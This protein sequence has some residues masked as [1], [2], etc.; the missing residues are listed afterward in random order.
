[1]SD[2]SP[3]TKGGTPVQIYDTTLR[4]GTQREGISLACAD[5]LRIAQQLDASRRRLHRGRLARLEPEGRRA[6]SG[7]RAMSSGRT[8]AL[9]AFGSTRRVGIAADDDPGLVALL[10]AET[11]VCT[12]FGKSSIV[13]VTDVLRTTR[14]ENLRDDRGE[15][16]LPR[17][18]RQARRLRRGALLRR[19]ARGRGV[20]AGDAPRRGARRRRGRRPLRHQ[21]R[22]VAVGGRGARP[23]AR[24]H[25]R[26]AHRHPRPRRR[27]V[28]RRELARRRARRRDA[29]AGHHQRIRRAL[30]ER[31]PHLD[32]P[33]PRAEAREAV[34]PRRRAHRRSR[35]SRAS[36]PRSPT[37]RSTSTPRTSVAAPSPTRAASTSQRSAGRLAPTSTSTRR[38]SEIARA[39]S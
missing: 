2:D 16:R 36:S 25:A 17:L 18:A 30:R 6:S 10:E 22:H 7:A 19:L 38:S 1:M 28:R 39:S 5:K 8:A 29:R 34:H 4:D 21:R 14:D 35:A 37:S 13:H 12:L 20:R 31:Q 26:P 3:E 27:R 33:E 24:L 15:R 23:R 11:P 9:A 32:H